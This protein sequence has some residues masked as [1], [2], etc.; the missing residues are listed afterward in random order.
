M[1]IPT[2]LT[3]R[4]ALRAPLAIDFETYR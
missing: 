2:L 3:E 1:H 4:L